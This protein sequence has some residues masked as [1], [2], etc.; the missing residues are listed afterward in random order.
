M[1]D[2]AVFDLNLEEIAQ[3]RETEIARVKITDP[4]TKRK[5]IVWFSLKV[6]DKNQVVANVTTRKGK[7][8]I[9]KSSV[10][11]WEET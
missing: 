6:N 7:T 4:R 9:R 2:T 1:I 10:A 3:K 11:N 8:E 5:T